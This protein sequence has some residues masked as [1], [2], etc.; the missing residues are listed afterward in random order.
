MANPTKYNISGLIRGFKDFGLPFSN[1]IYNATLTA[2]TDT[3]VAVP[4]PSGMGEIN[5]NGL[6]R[7]LALFT[8]APSATF[9]VSV[10]AAAAAPVGATFAAA[11]SIINPPW[12]LVKYG[13]TI[14]A[15]CVAGGSMAVEFFYISEA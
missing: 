15:L 10:N 11:S 8:Y 5:S 14:H 6:T 2:N 13:D 4:S 7:Y 9:W 12:K 1:Y 3:T